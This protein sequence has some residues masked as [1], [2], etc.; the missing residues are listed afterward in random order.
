[1]RWKASLLFVIIITIITTIIF[2][3]IIIIIVM[4]IVVVVVAVVMMI[5]VQRGQGH[6]PLLPRY[7]IMPVPTDVT[8]TPRTWGRT[9]LRTH[10]DRYTPTICLA[11]TYNSICMQIRSRH[12]S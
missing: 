4:I 7:P 9:P 10:T 2:I 3:I 6:L 12:C 11:A 8:W 5:N 1:M